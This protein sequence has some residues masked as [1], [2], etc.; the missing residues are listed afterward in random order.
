MQL[1]KVKNLYPIKS[2]EEL[3]DEELMIDI[4]RDL[5]SIAWDFWHDY[6]QRCQF[7]G[8]N[9]ETQW[10]KQRHYLADMFYR[11]QSYDRTR[12]ILVD[13]RKHNGRNKKGESNESI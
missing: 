12:P 6:I 4:Q 11:G 8:L 9:I 13:G 7:H 10:K 3:I 2:S 1:P 5:N